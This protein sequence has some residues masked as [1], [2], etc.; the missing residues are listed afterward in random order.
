MGLVFAA[1]TAATLQAESHTAIHSECDAAWCGDGHCD[2]GHCNECGECEHCYGV[3][4]DP[5]HPKKPCRTM[6]GDRDRGDCPPV[7]YRMDQDKRAGHADE[8]APWAICGRPNT[9]C[10]NYTAWFVGGGAAFSKIPQLP[11]PL[12]SRGRPREANGCGQF[13]E[14]TWGL[15]YEGLAGHS[16]VW[17]QYTQGRRQGGEGAYKTDGEPKLI[18]KIKETLHH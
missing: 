4:R 15:D 18:A 5:G 7:R 11:I 10:G 9:F 16:K 2:N 6:P 14:G 13:G 1:L 3:D 8:V 12:F 17:L